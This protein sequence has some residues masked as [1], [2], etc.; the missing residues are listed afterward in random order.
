MTEKN[1]FFEIITK[2]NEIFLQNI[3][4]PEVLIEKLLKTIAVD[5]KLKLIWFRIIKND[6]ILFSKPYDPASEYIN[7][8]K[9]YKKRMLQTSLSVIK[10]RKPLI[11]NDPL[12]DKRCE[13]VHENARK[14]SLKSTAV[15][16]NL[17]K[18]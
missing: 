2:T 13:Y 10:E 5:F 6:D 12:S 7:Q 15:F 4:N 3:N 17:T 9:E 18:R 1:N 16:S 8:S 14:Y 11:A